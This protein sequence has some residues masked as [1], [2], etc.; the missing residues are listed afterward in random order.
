M[1]ERRILV[2][3]DDPDGQEVVSR[4]LNHHRIPHVS[5]RSAEEALSVLHQGTALTGAIIDLALPGMDGWTLLNTIHGEAN[6]AG[7]PCV[8]MTAFHSSE[9]AVKAVQAGFEA[10][11]PKPLDSTAFVR[12]IERVFPN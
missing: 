7:L 6:T 12:E 2:V 10:Y 4:I 5:V 8:A 3:E 1:S 11:F 9:L